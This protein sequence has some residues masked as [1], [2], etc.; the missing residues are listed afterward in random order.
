MPFQ[1]KY[2]DAQFLEAVK[3]AT[4]MTEA[5]RLLNVADSS[6]KTFKK[7]LNR[8]KPDISHWIDIN[9]LKMNN[10][11]TGAV[12]IPLEE[13]LVENSTYIY[14]DLRKKLLKYGAIEEKCY[15][16]PLKNEWNGKPLV[17]QLDHINGVHNDNR[18]ENLRLLCPNC[19]SQTP[20]FCG[21]LEKTKM[22][23]CKYCSNHVKGKRA[24][25]CQQCYL[26][27]D[28]RTLNWVPDEELVRLLVENTFREVSK[29]LKINESSIR[30][31]VYKKGLNTQI[32]RCK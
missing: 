17:L 18:I 8:L 22:P 9:V 11:K 21:K 32:P 30:K 20:T 2:T 24:K 5:L 28:Y 4:Y 16:C 29:I 25:T 15:L 3:Q 7:V 26:N 31:R 14:S 27:K 13:V 10:F 23:K 19:H 1:R 12:E 6:G